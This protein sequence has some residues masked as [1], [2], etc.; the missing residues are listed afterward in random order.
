MAQLE[1]V[2][3]PPKG[4]A[5]LPAERAH[6][7]EYRNSSAGEDLPAGSLVLG[8]GLLPGE[9]SVADPDALVEDQATV[10][11]VTSYPIADGTH[12]DGVA[13]PV[14]LTL[15][16]NAHFLATSAYVVKGYGPQGEMVSETLLAPSGG[17]TVL[18]TGQ[19][20]AQVTEI[21]AGPHGGTAGVWDAGW[22][23]A[24]H[25]AKPFGFAVAKK[26]QETTA[27]VKEGDAFLLLTKGAIFAPMSGTLAPGSSVYA[28]P[29]GLL[30]NAAT[31]NYLVPALKVLEA[32][33]ELALVE[34]L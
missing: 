4:H 12:P 1:F 23:L 29:E 6:T 28:T 26:L 15:S 2:A 27:D 10:A 21:V 11:A 8:S 14:T 34:V 31:D 19:A 20:F 9:K 18:T 33:G 24:S 17:D 32:D 13:A 30:T 3:Q 22:A 16:D 5:G 25:V 7:N